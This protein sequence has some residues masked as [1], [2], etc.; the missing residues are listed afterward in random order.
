[1][2]GLVVTVGADK[3]SQR[4]AS[5]RNLKAGWY[6]GEGNPIGDNVRDITSELNQVAKLYGL[7]KR[8]VFPLPEGEI[9]LDVYIGDNIH[10]FTISNAGTITY[11]L[12]SADGT[13]EPEELSSCSI[14][15]KK[16]ASIS[17]RWNTSDTY[18]SQHIHGNTEGLRVTPSRIRMRTTQ[19]PLSVPSVRSMPQGIYVNMDEDFIIPHTRLLRNPQFS[20]HLIHKS[21]S[22]AVELS[23]SQVRQETFAIAI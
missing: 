14:A 20:S 16:L 12:E 5:F 18:T 4:I 11:V 7:N 8:E 10:E 17:G 1:M 9:E 15:I 2:N 6:S 13:T 22:P 3:V 21:S 23:K 19:Y